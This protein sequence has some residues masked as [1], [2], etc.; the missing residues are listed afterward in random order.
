MSTVATSTQDTVK[1]TVSD[2]QKMFG[3]EHKDDYATVNGL[4]KF[5]EKNGLAK[6]AGSR[7]SES[8]KGKP[9]TI[10][11]ISK[12]FNVNV[13]AIVKKAEAPVAA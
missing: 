13:E 2:F 10:W 9:A 7:R 11:E 3:L 12:S 6:V 5:L 4:L 8:G 1:G